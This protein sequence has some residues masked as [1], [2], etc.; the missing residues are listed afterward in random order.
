MTLSQDD[1]RTTTSATASP[2]FERDVLLLNGKE[3]VIEGSKRLTTLF[4]ELR[5]LRKKVEEKEGAS[6]TPLSEM[7]LRI[8]SENNFPT[9]AGLASSAAGFAALVKAVATLYKLPQNDEELSILARQGSGSAC[10][11]LFGGYVAW[12]MGEKADGSD[13][14][15]VQIAPVSHWPEMQAAILVVNAAKKDTAS[16]QGMQVTVN[17]SDLFCERV[18]NVVP[19]RF[20]EMKKSILDR[21]FEKF[22]E[23]TMKDSN[24]FHAVCLD[25]YPPVFYLN[26]VSR[27]I[28]RI[29]EQINIE[30]GKAV[31]AYTY[32]AGP[33]AV[34]YY[35]KEHENI[36]LGSIKSIVPDVFPKDN[37][38]KPFTAPGFD[39][40]WTSTIANGV[41]R[42]IL[43]KIGPGPQEISVHLVGGDGE[44][45]K[46]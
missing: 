6:S 39:Q 8:V 7:K 33:N 10:R 28:I 44:P 3:E 12:Q 22:A 21:D 31:A 38:I 34:I 42:V 25:S 41:E 23:L 26:D 43:T 15:A 17:T 18:N 1:L 35:Q 20:E 45:L 24:Q 13:S 37:N 36:V 4:R 40:R 30:A 14:K 46:K 11:S 5:A 16:T 29:V 27:C 2:K 19:R 32:D 9:A